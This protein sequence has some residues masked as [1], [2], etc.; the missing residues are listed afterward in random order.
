[1]DT[2]TVLVSLGGALLTG[3]GGTAIVTAITRRGRRKADVAEVLTDTAMDIMATFKADAKA[4]R[5]DA[6]AF[7]T[8]A[9]EARRQIVDLGQQAERLAHELRRIIGAIH[10]PAQT[11]DRLRVLVPAQA[12]TN[13][14]NL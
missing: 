10:E 11:L 1:V 6:A 14:H 13:G 8:E 7:K 4:A 3:G 9:A 12:S 2:G 5:E